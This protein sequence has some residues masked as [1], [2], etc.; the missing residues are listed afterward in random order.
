MRI[1]RMADIDTRIIIPIISIMAM[2]FLIVDVFKK[3]IMKINSSDSVI[4]YIIESMVFG[5]ISLV[6]PM[7]IIAIISD[8]IGS[9]SL[10]ERFVYIYLAIALAY[11][12]FKIYLWVRRKLPKLVL[13]E[14]KIP[15]GIEVLYTVIIGLMILFFTLQALVYPLRG[16]DFLHFYLPNSFRIYLTGQLGLINELNF[17]PQFKPPVNILL[18]AYGFFVTQTEMIHLIPILFIIGTVFLCYKIAIFEGLTKK[19]SL[20][21]SIALLATPFT[22]FLV[23]EFQYYQEIYITFFTTATYF[24]FRKFLKS[25]KFKNQ[26]YY[27][28]LASLALSGCVLSKVS[29]FVIPLI[30]LVAM[31][32]DMIGKVIRSIIVAGFAFQLIKSSIYEVF[33]GTGI[34]IFLLCT[35]C[36]YLI[37][38]SETLKFSYNRWLFILGIY[39]LPFIAALL[40]G[41]HILS[42]PGVQ[43]YLFNLYIDVPV[44]QIDLSWAGLALPETTT[45]L[46]N[47][48]TATFITSS[49]SIL[50]ATMFAGTWLFFKIFGFI[51]AHKKNNELMLWLIFFYVF[52]QGFFAMGSIRYLSPILVPLTILFV[53][54]I[55]AVVTFFNKRDGQ[56]RDGFLASIFLLASAYLS[57]Y[58][59]LP[60]E[61]I[62]EDFHLRWY[63]AH[64]HIWSLLGYII[65]FNI[66]IFTLIWQE[67]RLKI[68]FALIYTKKFNLR[69]IISGFLIFILFF[70]P[71]LAQFAL[72]IDTGFDLDEFHSK[73]SYFT[74]ETYQELVDAINRLGYPDK[75]AIITIN[76]PGL[77]Y[78]ASQPVI[79]LF[80]IGFIENSGLAN[81][82]FPLGITNVTRTL[83]FFEQYDVSIFVALNTSN[84]WYEAYQDRFYWNYFIYRFINNNEYFTWRFS[85]QEFIMYTINSYDPYVGPVDFQLV[86][87]ENKGS[88]LARSPDSVEISGDIG[89][90]GMELDLTAPQVTGLINMSVSTEYSSSS[91]STISVDNQNYQ[92]F[93]TAQEN[94][95]RFTLL[96]LP[97]ET[98]FLHSI[99]VDITYL[100]LEG[101][102]EEKSYS[103][104]PFQGTSV[105]ITRL[106]NS[107][108]Y[109]GFFGFIYS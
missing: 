103:L 94:F 18:F 69:K 59:V 76:T 74:R 43:E 21:S 49:F 30:I 105:N 25:K 93:K 14:K 9:T 34:L 64:T 90:I 46:E 16:W 35:F 33:L 1:N 79:D 67:K 2:G 4:D 102:E 55:D 71:F 7:L 47:A 5:S 104:Q 91:N 78:Y 86:G 48:H 56:E 80:M 96:S 57:L 27:A 106:A 68:N 3:K 44:T 100:N 41:L 8:K 17:M 36:I 37:F 84:D 82:T 15:Q 54:G 11:L 101:F 50:I 72:L 92:I 23:Y 108:F 6:V 24:F 52:W 89:S 58:P 85:N 81:S 95:L 70:T 99:N 38:S 83:E 32:S 73:Y 31:P 13:M 107:W 51:K 45:Y 66:L 22:F 109:E 12:I 19:S 65:L 61:I 77:E 88:L 87:P 39:S 29:G 60:F 10:L 63:H 98:V 97:F 42:I 20:L 75:L 40:W 62:A 53:I 26:F 28:L